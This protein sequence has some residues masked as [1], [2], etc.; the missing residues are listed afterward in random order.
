M[1]RYFAIAVVLVGI[2]ASIYFATKEWDKNTAEHQR[3]QSALKLRADFLERVPMLRSQ[4]EEK[5][6]RSEVQTFL[7][8][9]FKE[10]NEHLARHGGNKKF[11]DYLLELEDRSS[12]KSTKADDGSKEK[13]EDKKIVYEYSRKIFDQMKGGTY[14]PLYTQTSSGVRFDILSADV[15]H[16][17]GEEKIHLPL[18]VWGLPREERI[19][20]RKVKRISTSGTFKFNW[21]LF[22]EKGKL[23]GE[24]PGDGGPNSRVEWPDRYV[25]FFPPSVLL[26]HYDVDKLPQQAKV[27]EMSFSISGRTPTGGDVSANYTWKMDVPASWKLAAGETWKGAT[28]AERPEDEINPTKSAKNK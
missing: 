7:A 3:D 4:P 8:W 10:V 21:K 25:K 26:G 6:Y 14:A 12:K 19:D 27:V 22:D 5:A 9:Y 23:I 17:G 1:K 18:V 15:E 2:S 16:V 24:L 28:E 11:D 20:D 13:I